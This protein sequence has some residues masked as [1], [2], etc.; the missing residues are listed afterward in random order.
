MKSP[1]ETQELTFE[2]YLLSNYVDSPIVLSLNLNSTV[3]LPMTLAISKALGF[4]CVNSDFK[5]E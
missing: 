4:L 1:D 2:Q 3:N 5:K